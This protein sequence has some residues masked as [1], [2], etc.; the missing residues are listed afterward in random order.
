[1][2]YMCSLIQNLV[3]AIHT[4]KG[5]TPKRTT[6]I[7]FM[8][9]WAGDLKKQ[10]N[11]KQTVEEMK[12]ILLGFAKTHNERIDNENK[13]GSTKKRIIKDKK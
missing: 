5:V 12:Q 3:N 13:K 8:P 1:M 2:A 6:P 11:K 10:Q 4:K 9:D 7:D